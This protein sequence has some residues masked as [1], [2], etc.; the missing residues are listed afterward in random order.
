MCAVKVVVVASD[1]VT[2]YGWGIDACWQGLISGK[3]SIGRMDRFETKSF[4]T[5][6]AATITGLK[7]GQ[8]E[9]GEHSTGPRYT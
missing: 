8:N 9:S 2:A 4:Q 5:G 6:N 3:T 1:I 7:P